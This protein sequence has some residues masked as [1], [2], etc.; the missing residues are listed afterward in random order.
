M[1]KFIDWNLLVESA[2]SKDLEEF[3]NR[4]AKQ[5]ESDLET[6]FYV[7]PE[8]D[9]F[10][11]EGEPEQIGYLLTNDEARSMRLNF[12][13]EGDLFSV[14]YWKPKS[15]EPSVTV[16]LNDVPV[17]KAISKL[18]AFYKNPTPRVSEDEEVVTSK[19]P[20]ETKEADKKVIKAQKEV[21]YEFQNPEEIFEDLETY[22]N[23]VIDGDMYSL[24]LTGQAGVGKT[25]LVTKTLN[26]RGLE[27]NKDYFKITGKTTAAGMYMLLYQHNGKMLLFDDCDS[28]FQDDNAVNVLK[29]ALDTSKVREIAWTSAVPLKTPDKS[30][31]PKR[32]DFTGKVIFISNLPKRKIDP[33]IRSRSFVLEVALT[34][35]DMIERMW[36]LLPKVQLP[37]GAVVSGSIRRKA[38]DMIVEAAEESDNIELNMRTLI[39][40]ISI[41]N[42]ISDESVAKRLIKQQCAGA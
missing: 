27:R 36:S 15:D 37:S 18:I 2:S 11:R 1:I 14:D 6:D 23:M 29:G 42:R 8:F 24:L 12:T 16:Y 7:L 26:E 19:V 40:A 31:I 10:T 22:I 25:F 4:I 21:E 28:V 38:M 17:E 5:L 3:A 32:F 39:K 30:P 41:V 9:K 33:A 35:E 34:K 13:E 20:S